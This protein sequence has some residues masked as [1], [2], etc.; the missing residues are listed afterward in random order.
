[1]DDVTVKV[2]DNVQS[3][4]CALIGNKGSGKTLYLTYVG[5]TAHQEGRKVY[6]N[7][8]LY[9]IPY[10][11]VN[12]KV[13]TNLPEELNNGVILLDEAHM[14]ADAYEH[15]SKNSRAMTTLSTQ[16]RKRNLDLWI[17]TQRFNFLPRRIRQ[18]TDFIITLQNVYDFGE[19]IK[20]H[21]KVKIY[22]ADD[23]NKPVLTYNI[24]LTDF[25]D[26]YDTNQVIT[27]G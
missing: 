25:F 9:N 10:E 22:M 13:L 21:S 14:I 23:K 12:E 27:K 2:I 1:M 24:D 3:P 8:D 15:L 5:F 18:L 19:L 20:G 6:S 17:T 16:L 11:K 26:M 7:Y 4:I